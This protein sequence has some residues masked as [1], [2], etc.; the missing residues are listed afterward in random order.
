MLRHP[1]LL[2]TCAVCFGILVPVMAQ[3]RSRSGSRSS[4]SRAR[5]QTS[6]SI[7]GL[8]EPF[9]RV[10]VAAAETGLITELNVREG[11]KVQKGTVLAKLDDVVLQAALKIA[12]AQKDATGAV[13]VNEAELRLRASRFEKLKDLLDSGHATP[14]EVAV[15]RSEHEVAVAR[16]QQA[17]EALNVKKLEYH[18]AVAQV[19]RRTIRSPIDGV[20]TNV[21]RE[22]YEFVSYADPVVLTVVQLD[23]IVAVFT[24]TPQQVASL[25]TGQQVLVNFASTS[26][27]TQGR[28]SFISPVMDG[29]SGKLVV[30]VEVPN[31][32]GRFRAGDRCTLGST[33]TVMQTPKKIRK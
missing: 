29:E 11:Q 15:A 20:I 5:S 3:S 23:P 25:K 10:K 18:R 27:A 9:R 12:A 1:R 2:L 22:P 14:E 24:A 21:N 8:T 6:N 30:K 19:E 28:L 32:D 7:E 16:L 33:K 31:K 17:R 13:K 4:S 26:G